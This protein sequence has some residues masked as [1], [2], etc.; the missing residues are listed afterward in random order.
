MTLEQYIP[1]ADRKLPA[2]PGEVDSLL[3]A[4]PAKLPDDYV[5]FL[6]ESNGTE[7]HVGSAQRYLVLWPAGDILRLNADYGVSD[8]APHLLIVGSNGA[9]EAYGF[10]LSKEPVVFV[11]V[12]FIGFDEEVQMG[13]SLKEFL[14]RLADP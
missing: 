2:P 5:E 9:G 8:F 12:P 11:G 14:G 13:I 10:D 6:R 7:G 3:S 1:T 4:L